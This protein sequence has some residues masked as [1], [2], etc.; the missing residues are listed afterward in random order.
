MA[1][2]A[3]HENNGAFGDRADAIWLMVADLAVLHPEQL[4]EV[5]GVQGL[6]P[7]GCDLRPGDVHGA[8]IS[9]N[10]AVGKGNI[11]HKVKLAQ[12]FKVRCK[13]V[14]ARPQRG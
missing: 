5:L 1:V 2:A 6:G 13:N 8:A 11:C 4:G 3:A 12:V 7:R 9:E 14:V 10:V